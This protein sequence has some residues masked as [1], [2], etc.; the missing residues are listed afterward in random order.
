MVYQCGNHS[1]I[2]NLY[3]ALCW[4]FFNS[5]LRFF[6]SFMFALFCENS[7]MANVIVHTDWPLCLA[8]MWRVV[9]ICWKFNIVSKDK[10][11]FAEVLPQM[12]R[13]VSPKV[14]L[15][16]ITADLRHVSMKSSNG[17]Q[18]YSPTLTLCTLNKFVFVSVRWT[19]QFV[20]FLVANYSRL[21]H[22]PI[23]NWRIGQWAWS[24]SQPI[25]E[26][27]YSN[28]KECF[29]M[30]WKLWKYY[31]AYEI[32]KHVCNFNQ[33]R[34][35]KSMH[36]IFFYVFY[37]YCYFITI[38]DVVFVVWLLLLLLLFQLLFNLFNNG[39][40]FNRIKYVGRFHG[41]WIDTFNWNVN[42]VY[43]FS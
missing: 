30:P 11:N 4:N 28:T 37:I 5:K 2:S 43:W 3:H 6:V 40:H 31:Y 36:I 24:H 20:I 12:K 41:F 16:H 14:L 35:T 32:E 26:K 13:K 29:E 38:F 15:F 1:V 10:K 9:C 7:K 42:L 25:Q 21:I 39:K 23:T 33:K 18:D 34:K 8:E 27:N 17:F 19:C 22:L